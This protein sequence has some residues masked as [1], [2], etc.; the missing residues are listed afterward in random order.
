M[1]YTTDQLFDKVILN[2]DSYFSEYEKELIIEDI[3]HLQILAHPMGVVND[4][5]INKLDELSNKSLYLIHIWQNEIY[6][7]KFFKE[8]GRN[9]PSQ[10]IFGVFV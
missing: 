9:P 10:N 3:V 1:N 4:S 8:C 2:G 7:M 5:H 6:A